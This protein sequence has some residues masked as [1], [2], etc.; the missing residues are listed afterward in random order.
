MYLQMYLD[1]LFGYWLPFRFCA[2]VIFH[3]VK[4]YLK[5]SQT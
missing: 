1:G 3:W 4:L 2:I 5:R